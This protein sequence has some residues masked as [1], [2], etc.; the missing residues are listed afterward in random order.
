[1][2]LQPERLDILLA[3][4]AELV[5][6]LLKSSQ[7]PRA[8][9]SEFLHG[10]KRF[11]TAEKALISSTAHHVLRCWRPAATAVRMACGSDDAYRDVDPRIDAAMSAEALAASILL[12]LPNTS[13]FN[14]PLPLPNELASAADKEMLEDAACRM[15]AGDG[16]T[17]AEAVLSGAVSI[18]A[19]NNSP[20]VR[21]SLPDWMVASWRDAE[22][23]FS[24]DEIAD[25]GAAF[26]HA[27]P[28]TLR[29]NTLRCSRERLLLLL[30][31]E[32]FEARPHPALPDAVTVTER[33]ALTELGLYKE[34]CF[35][36]QD[37]GSQVIA[38]ATG[39][40]AG[41]RVYD[42][43][44]GGGGKTMQL[45]GMMRDSGTL[46]AS[47]IERN[48]LRGLRQR[49]SR[50]DLRS[51]R[52]LAVTPRGDA[53]DPTEPFPAA[54][55]FDV[56]MVDAP[57]SGA[58]TLRRNPALK[59]RLRPR[60]VERL[61]RRQF[62][63]LHNSARHVRSGGTLVYATCS[64][65]PQENRQVIERFLSTEASFTG[66]PLP[67]VFE[68]AGFHPPISADV[69]MWT[70]PPSLLDSDGYFVARL[71]RCG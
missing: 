9:T 25:Y 63:I 6:L 27:A 22:P 36:V 10:R 68:D 5:R 12:A 66:D 21:W 17:T 52:T 31:D 46:L 24:D 32:G 35:E 60:T 14:P 26:L 56:V 4:A 61:A 1:M 20:G 39:A 48:K 71:R 13:P 57:C 58:G 28:L 2:T 50:L 8:L 34:G 11:D 37:A 47:D 64:M 59:W 23:A 29:T 19:K 45:A 38:M 65:L 15:L 55:R 67:A 53:Q 16:D 49:A 70:I 51:L 7:P 3:Q 33:T 18:A 42:V 43:C 40:R 30:G 69:F 62:D 41:A 54:A 44:A